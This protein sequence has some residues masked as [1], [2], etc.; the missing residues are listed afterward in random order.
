MTKQVMFETKLSRV[1]VC[2][3]GSYIL[4]KLLGRYEIILTVANLGLRGPSSNT[5]SCLQQKKDNK[6]RRA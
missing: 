5:H 3:Y 2:Y 4:E 1:F 6:A